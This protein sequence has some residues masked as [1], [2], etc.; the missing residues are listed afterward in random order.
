MA[1]VKIPAWPRGVAG[2]VWANKL[3]DSSLYAVESDLFSYTAGTAVPIFGIPE[4]SIIWAIGC[5]IVTAF[6]GVLSTGEIVVHDTAAGGVESGPLAVFGPGVMNDV[7]NAEQL[8]MRRYVKGAGIG[9]GSK[10]IQVTLDAGGA[11]AGTF[12]IW[13]VLKPNRGSFKRDFVA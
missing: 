10:G 11:S 8:V 7:Q 3:A 2:N 13:L 5:E 4:D 12:R 9:T 6:T 1:A